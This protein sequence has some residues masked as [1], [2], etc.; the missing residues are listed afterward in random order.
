MRM[1]IFSAG[2]YN[3]LMADDDNNI[4]IVYT[5]QNDLWRR[6]FPADGLFLYRKGVGGSLPRQFCCRCLDIVG[7]PLVLFFQ[8]NYLGE[9]PC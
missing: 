7:K 9:M 6:R 4:H 3:R 2:R 5:D 1:I 8:G